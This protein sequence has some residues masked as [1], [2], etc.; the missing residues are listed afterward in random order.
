MAWEWLGMLRAML[1]GPDAPQ[2]YPREKR[3]TLRPVPALPVRTGP[4]L[5]ATDEITEPPTDKTQVILREYE[6]TEQTP[7]A[8]SGTAVVVLDPSDAVPPVQAPLHRHAP[9]VQN[10]SNARRDV[11][12]PMSRREWLYLS[13]EAEQARQ[14][15]HT[16]LRTRLGLPT[17]PE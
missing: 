14:P 12:L 16:Y 17:L 8:P 3:L 5:E 4:S 11:Y 15:L 7:P 6:V 1:K 13:H 9:W 2:P 10:R